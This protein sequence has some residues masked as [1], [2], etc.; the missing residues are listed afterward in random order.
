M[1][2]K[3]FESLWSKLRDKLAD[4][5][6]DVDDGPSRFGKES[7]TN[8]RSVSSLFLILFCLWLFCEA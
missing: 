8:F 3:F 2:Y 7:E 1:Q 6:D 5:V 4:S